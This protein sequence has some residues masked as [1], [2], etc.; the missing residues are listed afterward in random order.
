MQFGYI[1]AIIGGVAALAGALHAIYKLLH[2]IND[3]IGVDEDGRTL[4]ERMTRVEY[5][6]WENGG[7]SMKDQVN[8]N[9]TL[10]QTTA[11]EVKFIK[12]VMVQIIATPGVPIDH[13]ENKK[14]R[15][16]KTSAA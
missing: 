1:A 7:E 13:P 2:K 11:A 6:L 9:T 14:P 15:K 16:K 5:Q 12:D 4:S 10:A 8:A 3:A